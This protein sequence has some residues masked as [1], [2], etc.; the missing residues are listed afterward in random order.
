[1]SHPRPCPPRPSDDFNMEIIQLHIARITAI[2][3]DFQ[4]LLGS[5]TYIVSWKNPA[6]TSLSLLM[7]VATCLRFNAEYTGW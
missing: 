3:E 1:M 4:R 5:Y 2:V 7:F 6:L